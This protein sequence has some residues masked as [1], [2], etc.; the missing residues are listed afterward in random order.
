MSE[1]S[2]VGTI[3]ETNEQLRESFAHLARKI[4]QCASDE[5]ASELLYSFMRE[6]IK[7]SLPGLKALLD[8]KFPPKQE[9]NDPS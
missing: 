4:R 6:V 8:H 5:E 7:V 9:S 2:N 3:E 1:E